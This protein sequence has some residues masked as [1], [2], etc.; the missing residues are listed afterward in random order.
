[1]QQQVSRL[2]TV[3]LL[4]EAELRVLFWEQPSSEG[5]GWP[6]G[7]PGKCGFGFREASCKL[8]ASVFRDDKL[9]N[10]HK[11]PAISTKERGK[12]EAVRRRASNQSPGEDGR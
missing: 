11:R 9:R 2:Q 4:L 12:V 5:P 8:V 7:P 6:E 1:M 10:S 3:Q